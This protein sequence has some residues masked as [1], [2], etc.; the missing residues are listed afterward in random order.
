MQERIKIAEAYFA[1]KSVVQTQRQF[2]R[3][4]AGRNTSTRLTI[5]RILDKFRETGSV[6]N[7]INGRSGRPHSVTTENHVK[8]VSCL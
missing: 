7:N 3:D 6:L 5:K 1:T 8:T 2:R 4:F